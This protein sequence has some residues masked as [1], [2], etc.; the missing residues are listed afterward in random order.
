MSLTWK[1]IF[2]FL[3]ALVL[4]VAQMLTSGYFT[5]R[6]QAAS[7]QVSEALTACLAVQAAIDATREVQHQV[8]NE[9]DG[10]ARFDAV[11]AR[12]YV[13]ELTARSAE[14]AGPLATNDRRAVAHL[15]RCLARVDTGLRELD[16][17][18]RGEARGDGLAFLSDDL[19]ELEQ[20]FSQ[21][22]AQLRDVGRAGIAVER[23]VHD[24][25][26]RA[27]LLITLGGVVVMAAFVLWYKRQ[28]VVPIERAWSELEQRVQDRTA[29]LAAA[30][31]AADTA[32]R[33]KTAFLA[34][35]SHELRTP[36]TAILGF[37]EL[38]AEGDGAG[39]DEPLQREAVATVRRNAEAMVAIVNDLLD[40]SKLEAGKLNVERIACAPLQVVDDVVALLRGK[41]VAGQVTLRAVVP[42]PVPGRIRTDPLRLRQ[43]LVNLADNAIKFSKGG[44]VVL[45]V[46]YAGEAEPAMLRI[47]VC[48]SGIGM[49]ANVL[50]RLFQPF[51]QADVS[52]TRRYGGTGLG[53]A[54]SRQLARLLGGDL[55]A[56]SEAGKG[57]RFTLTIATGVAEGSEGPRSEAVATVPAAGEARPLAG[58]AVL[59][60]EDGPDNQRLLRHLLERAGCR[61]EIVANGQECLDRMARADAAF[62]V[63]LMDMQMPVM[64]GLTATRALRERGSVVPIVA[65]TANAMQADRDVA[66]AAGCDAFLT[67]P[68]DRRLLLS[69]IQEWRGRRVG[70][71]ATTT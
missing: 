44:E 23:G 4:Q 53:L 60:V 47:E 68:I 45:T 26:F 70:P 48:D 36:M 32:N 3:F 17:A 71:A 52:T 42:G 41:A 13:D 69:T 22:Q 29:E 35:I 5:S 8:D 59:L 34:N 67:K 61:L 21:A 46:T 20:A 54:I 38:L 66:L 14:L 24:L 43:I 40:M 56:T 33:T 16:G 19:R 31:D 58:T 15:Q 51:E 18:L 27:A 65:L 1:L 11:V 30:R 39:P 55:V 49:S 6:M 37:A 62:D 2:G 9:V 64:D 57:S 12:V 10:K 7:E 63:V 25:P 28:M 50:A